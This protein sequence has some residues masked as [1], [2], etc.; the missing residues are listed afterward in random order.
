M[1]QRR[2][3]AEV[4]QTRAKSNLCACFWVTV[5]LILTLIEHVL[6]QPIPPLAQLV[7]AGRAQRMLHAPPPAHHA[8]QE[9]V[10]LLTR[11]RVRLVD[12]RFLFNKCLISAQHFRQDLY[13]KAPSLHP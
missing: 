1:A 12:L 4:G 2:E 13:K 7:F 9:C 8:Q 3:V 6:L 10:L 11:R 5:C